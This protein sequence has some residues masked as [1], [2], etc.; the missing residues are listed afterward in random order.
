M[1][2]SKQD[3]FFFIPKIF[4]NNLILSCY[5]LSF[6]VSLIFN[7]ISKDPKW[8]IS[9]LIYVTI[10][11]SR[12]IEFFLQGSLHAKLKF[13]NEHNQT[14]V[15]KI[16]KHNQDSH[17]YCKISEITK[18]D[19]ILFEKDDYVPLKVVVVSGQAIISLEKATGQI[20]SVLVEEG[21]EILPGSVILTENV[22]VK[23]DHKQSFIETFEKLKNPEE[24]WQKHHFYD[25]TL[26]FF[27]SSISF[28]F[29]I[30]CLILNSL[31]SY[32]DRSF[33]PILLVAF[34][35]ALIP[36]TNAFLNQILLIFAANKLSKQGIAVANYDSLDLCAHI[37]V[38]F[39][40]KTGTIT[41]GREFVQIHN[42][43]NLSEEKLHEKI[44]LSSFFDNSP[45]G[46][47]IREFCKEKLASEKINELLNFVKNSTKIKFSSQS[48]ISG[49]NYEQNKLRKGAFINIKEFLNRYGQNYYEL[50]FDDLVKS[51]ILKIEENANKNGNGLMFLAENHQII[52]AIEFSEKIKKDC[53]KYLRKLDLFDIETILISGDEEKATKRLAELLLLNHQIASC[54][55]ID[56]YEYV[57]NY[58]KKDKIVAYVGDG[59]NDLP[60]I[61]SANIGICLGN[62]EAILKNSADI[63]LTN[64]SPNKIVELITL[65]KQILSIRGN[66]TF[67]SLTS[68]IT[69]FYLMTI[70]IIETIFPEFKALNF[71]E[72]A[73]SSKEVGV[74]LLIAGISYNLLTIFMFLPKIFL[75]NKFKANVSSQLLLKNLLLYGSLGIVS[76]LIFIQIMMTIL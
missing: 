6:Y 31:L 42:L 7:I 53:E 50:K 4:H 8:T 55:P 67:F 54:K 46:L 21:E 65:C 27:L 18:N 66:M 11:S 9:I 36:C 16:N 52:G 2:K 47:V 30:L 13:I 29:L 14:Y 71:L 40:D 20:H 62:S 23:I 45:E 1:L 37:N 10:F 70:A 64:D 12:S 56:K 34:F 15:K 17:Q 24:I 3:Q 69:K 58:Q 75:F 43:N 74:N 32:Y 44:F 48:P 33:S 49:I 63:I 73:G 38:I 35:I 57:I 28:I 5:D 22:I 39:F 41:Q 26:K 76:P 59:I 51:N 72:T 61:E 25:S 60:A 68:D 19:F